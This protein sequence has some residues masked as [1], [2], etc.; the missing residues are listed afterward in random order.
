MVKRLIIL[1]LL[2]SNITLAQ[3]FGKEDVKK[4]LKYSTFYAAV[5]GGTSISDV[6]TFSIID[7]LQTSTIETPY[8]YSFTIGIRK[9]ARFGYE[10]K[11]QT[12]YDGT[13]SNYTDAATVG[14]VKGFEY[15]FEIDYARQQGVDYIDQ[16]HFIRYSSDDNC[17]GP[18]CIDHFAAKVEYVKDGFE[19]ELKREIIAITTDKKHLTYLEC[20]HQFALGVLEKSE[21]L[22]DNILGKFF[23]K[24]FA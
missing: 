1:L 17:D 20:K 12:F 22:N 2:V 21:Y 4:L 8:D 6:K 19:H 9:I 16:H 3:T 5:N 14:K 13:E 7:G 18:F 10:N 23:D 24:D 11:A 15:L